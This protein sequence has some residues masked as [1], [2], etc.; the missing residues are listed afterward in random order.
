MVVV[1]YFGKD[2]KAPITLLELGYILGKG[3]NVIVG[4]EE[5]FWKR[6]NVDI[7]CRRSGVEIVSTLQELMTKVFETIEERGTL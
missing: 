2:A 1:V 4:C 5:G 6:G 3:K 7:I